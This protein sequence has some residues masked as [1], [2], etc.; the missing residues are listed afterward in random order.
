[1]KPCSELHDS[2]VYAVVAHPSGSQAEFPGDDA[3]E[4]FAFDTCLA[5][6]ERY[7]GTPLAASSLDAFPLWP[8]L[9]TW[10][11]GDRSV[12]CVLFDADLAKLEGS[13]E[14]SGR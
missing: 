9:Y 11:G 4:A 6:F 7:V 1:V 3:L 14:G 10:L 8:Y 2:E 5:E 13:M 12:V